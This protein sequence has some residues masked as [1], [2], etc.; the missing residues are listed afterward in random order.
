MESTTRASQVSAAFVRIAQ[1]LV[2]DYDVLDLAQTLV[3]EC[4]DLLDASAAGLMLAGPDGVLQ[5]LAS[6]SEETYVIEVL[7]QESG[8]GPCMECY[9]T[10]VPVTIHDIAGTGNRWP[11]FRDAAAAQGYK[12]MHAFPLRAH[13][14]TIGAMNLFRPAVGE[15]SAEDVAIGQALADVSTISILQERTIQQSAVVN[16]QLQRA[17]DSRILTEQAKGMIAH[18]VNVSTSE[19][20]QL[21]RAYARSHN[22]TLRDTA[23]AVLRRELTLPPSPAHARR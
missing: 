17:L 4:V 2:T 13:G 12:S 6:T 19:A 9:T 3:E 23:E 14:R 22:T 21:L 16:D 5:V 8:A 7:Q 15:L 11:T 1:T 20:F 18:M 10:G